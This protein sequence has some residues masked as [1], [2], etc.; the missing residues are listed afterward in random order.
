[1]AGRHHGGG[2]RADRYIG[3]ASVS[4]TDWLL[5]RPIAKIRKK[6]RAHICFDSGKLH[7]RKSVE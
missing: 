4:I 1:V 5:A 7:F 6:N 3:T 2:M